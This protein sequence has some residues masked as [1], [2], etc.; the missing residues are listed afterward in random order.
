MEKLIKYWVYDLID[1]FDF[2]NYSYYYFT[3]AK[4]ERR[5]FNKKAKERMGAELKASMLKKKEPWTLLHS[6]NEDGKEVK[7]YSA[8]WKSV[9]FNEN[10]ISI[11]MDNEPTFS[12]PYSWE[13]SEEKFNLLT[14][15]ISGRRLNELKIKA[16]DSRI[17]NIEGL[18][19]LE[20]IIWKIQIQKAIESGESNHTTN[21]GE[22]RIPV[23]MILRN[24][25]IQFL[26]KLQLK[27][28]EPARI[29]EKQFN[30]NSG[31]FS[32][33]I[34]LLYS[35]QLNDNEIAI[36]W[37]SLE[38]DKSKATHVFKCVREEYEDLFN[39]IKYYLSTESKTRSSLNSNN[40]EDK[41]NQK[42]LGYLA[43]VDHDNFN[44]QKWENSLL[45][46]IPELRSKFSLEQI[47]SD[48]EQH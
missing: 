8:T 13:F 18:E 48:K 24:E 39:N 3:L 14:D 26:N 20:E 15:Y 44:Y 25:C 27:G 35:I 32:I 34:S 33:D 31:G 9:W 16:I 10:K 2:K 23:N 12:A 41:E 19:E 43:R 40:K 11:C 1:Y 17:L 30:I 38:L 46:I 45:E 42:K 28:L 21:L 36:I 5:I 29:L 4:D 22:N 47:F 7:V 37:E 6:I